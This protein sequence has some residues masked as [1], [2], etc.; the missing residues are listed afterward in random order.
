M[1]DL[2]IVSRSNTKVGIPDEAMIFGD[3]T[4]SP[5]V[6]RFIMMPIFVLAAKVCPDGAEA[7]LFA[8][9]MALSNFGQAVAI[10]FGTFLVV[11]FDVTDENFDNL[12]W[13]IV[14]K[15]LCRLLPIPLIFLLV[16]HGCPQDDN[17]DDDD[18]DQET[19]GGISV[20]AAHG[21]IRSP[22]I[23]NGGDNT[24][25]IQTSEI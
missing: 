18:E 12:F 8:M 14:V 21:G 2:V 24:N 4:L 1:L 15:S 5:M 7:T 16:P 20:P 10:Y 9:L 3:A 25:P 6:R 22:L 17:G 13:V 23:D 11:L 19:I